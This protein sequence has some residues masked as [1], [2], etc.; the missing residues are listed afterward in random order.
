MPNK[1]I[2][3]PD[4]LAAQTLVYEPIGW[5]CKN[6]V[7]ETESEEYGAFDFELNQHRIKFRV[8]KIT[9]TKIG[10]FVT[11]WKRIGTGPIQPY[12]MADPIDFFIVSVRDGARF[13]QFIFPK[14]VLCAKG[15]VSKDGN[16]GKR[17]MRVYPAW[18]IA[19]NPQAKKTQAWQLQYFFE[20]LAAHDVNEKLAQE[21]FR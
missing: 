17:A 16:G 10:Q 9:P 2:P 8:A 12:D 3:H 13:G 19:E 15:I 20:I 5:A 6:L 1:P 4:L 21:F 11:L 14:A 7:K 18:D